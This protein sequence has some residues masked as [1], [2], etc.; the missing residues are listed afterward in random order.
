M[1]KKV[2]P[3]A[4]LTR[5]LFR[6]PIYLYRLK[7]RVAVRYTPPAAQHIGRI[8]GKPRQTILEVAEHDATN[9]SYVLASG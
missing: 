9:N 8:S 7:L 4:G 2:Q 3:P 1:V 5:S 6:P